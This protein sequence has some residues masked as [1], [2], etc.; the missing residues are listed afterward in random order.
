MTKKVSNIGQ[1]IE[2]DI[3]IG[4]GIGIGAIVGVNVVVG[5]ESR[6]WR[7]EGCG[8]DRDDIIDT[9]VRFEG[10]W[11]GYA[12]KNVKLGETKVGT[13]GMEG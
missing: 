1:D 11:V 8:R 9:G 13:G 4:V 3:G 12:S 5:G 2:E 6:S 7:L 10:L